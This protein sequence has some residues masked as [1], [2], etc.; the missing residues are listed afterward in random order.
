MGRAL[1]ALN[2]I[3]RNWLAVRSKQADRLRLIAEERHE[4]VDR[5]DRRGLRGALSVHCCEQWAQLWRSTMQC[6]ESLTPVKLL[7]YS[8]VSASDGVIAAAGATPRPRGAPGL[9]IRL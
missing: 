2:N 8:M 5:F 9:R 1:G 4:C 7:H 6:S 3:E